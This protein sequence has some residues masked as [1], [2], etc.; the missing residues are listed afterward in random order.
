MLQT[1]GNT[2]DLGLTKLLLSDIAKLRKMPTVAKRI[3]EYQPQPDPLV[4]MEK[5]LQIKLLQ[6]QIAKEESLAML[7]G[8]EAQLQGVQG[9]K[10]ATQAKLNEAKAG[11][12]IAKTRALGS[13]ADLKDLD[14]LEQES[15]VHQA[16]DVEKMGI[17]A[18][19]D[20]E[21]KQ[22]ANLQE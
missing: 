4:E 15:G 8:A 12:E 2:M 16:R 22:A 6:A 11:T 1:T 21:A 18:L 13:D 20:R 17:K 19:Y 14:F 9:A 3:E 5:E 7:H 10:E